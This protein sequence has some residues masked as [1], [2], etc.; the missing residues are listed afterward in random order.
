MEEL[1]DNEL[2]RGR[3]MI[4]NMINKTGTKNMITEAQTSIETI[5][6]NI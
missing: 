1:D 4:N 2:M 5:N 3:R 6:K